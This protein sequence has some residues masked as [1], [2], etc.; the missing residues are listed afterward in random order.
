MSHLPQI[1]EMLQNTGVGAIQPA[2]NRTSVNPAP[3][4]SDSNSIQR[5]GLS[6]ILSPME[7]NKIPS[8]GA[9]AQ[10]ATMGN[11]AV[12]TQSV[13]QHLAWPDNTQ[14]LGDA[15]SRKYSPYSIY[16]EQKR[17]QRMLNSTNQD[18][19]DDDEDE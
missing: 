16:L 14:S 6:T 3:V 12:A 18:D 2:I 1:I 9:A 8:S 17:Q 15:L 4:K 10:A 5:R 11:P 7:A 13:N 19:D